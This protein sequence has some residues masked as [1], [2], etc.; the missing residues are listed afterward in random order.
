M[1][2]IGVFGCAVCWI[3]VLASGL[4]RVY[5]LRVLLFSMHDVF[6][7]WCELALALAAWAVILEMQVPHRA[8][9]DVCLHPCPRPCP[10]QQ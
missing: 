6:F 1:G 4:P 3:N 8:P 5:H 10:R 2:C 9:E 7:V